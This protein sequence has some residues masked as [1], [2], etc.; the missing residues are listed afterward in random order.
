MI[1][2]IFLLTAVV[3]I[4]QNKSRSSLVLAGIQLGW[5]T[6]FLLEM[7]GPL[8]VRSLSWA[9]DTYQVIGFGGF[10]LIFGGMAMIMLWVFDRW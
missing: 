1:I 8:I 4:W 7:Y 10:M 5:A 3:M 6:A 2:T 9:W